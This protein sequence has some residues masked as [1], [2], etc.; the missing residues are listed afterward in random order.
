MFNTSPLSV[1]ETPKWKCAIGIG[2]GNLCF[3]NN[4]YNVDEGSH[5][6]MFSEKVYEKLF[7]FDLNMHQ[8][9]IASRKNNMLSY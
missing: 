9:S 3:M 5:M 4:V 6:Y 8:Y 7:N 2:S 1:M